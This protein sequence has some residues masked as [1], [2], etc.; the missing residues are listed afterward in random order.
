M[1]KELA[2]LTQINAKGNIV[3]NSFPEI[4]NRK[5]TKFLKSSIM[6]TDGTFIKYS[7]TTTGII[8]YGTDTT[9]VLWTVLHTT[10]GAS[11]TNITNVFIDETGGFVYAIALNSASPY[12]HQFFKIAIST[13]TVTTVGSTWVPTT[14]GSSISSVPYF[15]GTFFYGFAVGNG[16]STAVQVKINVSTGAKTEQAMPYSSVGSVIFTSATDAWSVILTVSSTTTHFQTVA[17]KI[18]VGS[19]VYY[20]PMG[21]FPIL[22]GVISSNSSLLAHNDYI[23][24]NSANIEFN[25]TFER[26]SI[27]NFVNYLINRHVA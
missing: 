12:T 21:V 7:N 1:S 25:N 20:I 9:T 3:Q 11:Y 2:V 8:K 26:Q 6:L 15:D 18:G 19:F 16:A 5:Q 10:V 23:N 13:G 24:F 27:T 17:E 4:K 22:S 14:N